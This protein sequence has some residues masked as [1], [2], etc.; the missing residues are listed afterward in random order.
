MA[1]LKKAKMREMPDA[2]LQ[3]KLFEFQKELNL[4]RG[5]LA[6][7]GRPANTGKI[8]E[9]KRSV[10][11]ILTILHERKLGIARK[12]KDKGKNEEETKK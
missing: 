12:P 7:G 3:A 8:S 1:I 9:L 5:L 6:S 4:E 2:E 11:R 10:A